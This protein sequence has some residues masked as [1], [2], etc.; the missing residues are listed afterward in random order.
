MIDVNYCSTSIVVVGSTNGSDGGKMI[1][2]DDD[3]TKSG[4]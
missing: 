1:V 2:V 3:R 4:A